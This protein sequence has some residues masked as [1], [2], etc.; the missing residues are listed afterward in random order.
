[1][2]ALQCIAGHKGIR[3]IGISSYFGSASHTLEFGKK[4]FLFFIENDSFVSG[5]TVTAAEEGFASAE[6]LHVYSF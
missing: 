1:M 2:G 4:F 3:V 6:A 5:Q